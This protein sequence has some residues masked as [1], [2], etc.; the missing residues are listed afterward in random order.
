MQLLLLAGVWLIF[1]QYDGYPECVWRP[2]VHGIDCCFS[3]K[4]D[5][6]Q[7][8][9]SQMLLCYRLSLFAGDASSTTL[10][11]SEWDDITVGDLT[12]PLI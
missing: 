12:R 8:D 4:L 6:S 10:S 1:E 9:L 7:P 5:G 11:S 3:V 2:F